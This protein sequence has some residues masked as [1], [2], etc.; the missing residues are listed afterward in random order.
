MPPRVRKV[1]VLRH[2]SGKSPYW[3]LRWWESFDGGKTWKERW[4]STK[5]RVKKEAERQR[6]LLEH[7][8]DTGHDSGTEWLWEDLVAEYFR[9]HRGRLAPT[10]LGAYKNS[11]DIFTKLM[12]PQNVSQIQIDTL[13]DFIH[14]RLREEIAPATINRDLRHLRLVLKWAKRRG[15]T[16]GIPDFTGMFIKEDQ[17]DPTIIPEEDFLALVATLRKPDLP[18]KIRPAAWWRMFFYI[19]YYLGVRRGE[20]LGLSWGSITFDAHE[21]RVYAPTSKGR[22]ERVVP[23]APD[24]TQILAVWKAECSETGPL[25]PVL[26]WPYDTLRP[27]YVDWHLIQDAAGIPKGQHY[28]PQDCRSSCASEL[29]AKNV[30][31][32]VVRDFLGHANVSTTERY[33]INTK[34]ALR[35]AANVRRIAVETEPNSLP[36]NSVEKSPQDDARQE[37]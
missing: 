26:P 28:V 19:T 24:L 34:P 12:N 1:K 35:A 3:Y 27:L 6:R 9:K 32:V 2:P 4:R 14:A 7:E 13:E 10:T 17:K 5:T 23:M 15:L 21:V 33:Y 8:L 20:A 37:M 29:T 25:D 18:L 30:P 31:T 36:D 11:L 22:R 16:N